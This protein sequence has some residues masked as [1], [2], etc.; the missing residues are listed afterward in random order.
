MPAAQKPQSGSASRQTP[1][2]ENNG[3]DGFKSPTKQSQPPQQSGDKAPQG[4]PKKESDVALGK[5]G[6][7]WQDEETTDS[8]FFEVHQSEGIAF[9]HAKA[10]SKAVSCYTKVMALIYTQA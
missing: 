9:Q 4:S 5:P 2:D 6:N 8:S 1:T 10:W 7:A 3:A